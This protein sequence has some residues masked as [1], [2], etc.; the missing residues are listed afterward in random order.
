MIKVETVD[1]A[2]RGIELPSDRVGMV[3]AQPYLTLTNHEPY[4][5]IETAKQAQ[6]A[7]LSETLTVART[8]THDSP[9][10]H[11]TIIPEYSIPGVDGV[12]L[13]DAALNEE[14]WPR[15]TIVI[16]GT[17][18]LS[19]AEFQALAK[20]NHTHVDAE[21]NGSDTILDSEWINCCITWIK[22]ADGTVERWLQPK[23][24]R[25]WPEQDI[26]NQEMFLGKSAFTFKGPLNNGTQYRFSTLVC[27]DWIAILGDKKAWRWVLDGL[28]QQAAQAG[29]E[30]I[31][32][33]WFFVIQ[34]NRRP[35]HDSF[36]SEVSDF[37]DQTL[38]PSV[39]RERTCLIFANT[40]GKAVPGASEVFGATSA[41]FA[42]QTLFTDPKCHPTFSNGGARFRSSTLLSAH[43]DTFFRESGACIHS[44]SQVNPS[45]LNAGA[46]GKTI[47]LDHAFV[48]PLGN[49]VDPRAPRAA[50]P[51]SVKWLNDELDVIPSLNVQYPGVA[52]AGQ[53][54]VA[55]QQ[56]V[57]ALR[58]LRG[59]SIDHAVR[60][61]A[62]GSGA[63]HADEWAVTERAAVEHLVHTLDIIGV[64]FQPLTIG[65]D[66]AH[67]TVAM[68]NQ[69]VD[70][71]A[72]RGG[73]HE[74]CI[75]HSRSFIPLPRR[76]VLLVSRDP[77][78]TA[79]KRRFGSFLATE[80]AAPGEE[81]KFTDPEAGSLHL[82]YEK[83]LDVFRTSSTT[84]SVQERINAELAA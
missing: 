43:R 29:A 81:R 9:I 34:H 3:I 8:P 16:G 47:A 24:S 77:D 68:D 61:A 27:F 33:S 21:Q 15:G 67:A 22:S 56:S 40:A 59:Q 6:L 54:T 46:A 2:S 1:L 52:L 35:S 25:A 49:V 69:P 5:C 51:A 12:A 57:Y 50:V 53:M 31:S 75:E 78:N 62:C 11:F 10:T 39:R 58:Y 79:W 42:G 41:V 84:A 71:L 72:I 18:A 30:Q 45:S 70:L 82:G 20:A 32:L 7:V 17:D 38:F 80:N 63:A 14:R 26:S 28:Q 73:S 76:P 55:H 19:K 74:A 23:L 4:K 13:I 60:L 48:F 65:A 37:F 44:F 83:L 66:P 36:L 64:A